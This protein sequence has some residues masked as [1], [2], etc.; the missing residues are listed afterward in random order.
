MTIDKLDMLF[1]IA[2]ENGIMIEYV[3]FP[4]NMEGLYYKDEDIPPVI[5]IDKRITYDKKLFTCVL[6]E[7][8]GHHFTTVGDCTAEY[9]CY[10]DRLI[11]N[12]KETLALKWATEFLMP[13]EEIIDYVKNNYCSFGELADKLQVTE[14]FL[15]KRFE[16]I[17]RHS[18]YIKIDNS[19]CI[20]LT[21]LPNIYFSKLF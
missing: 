11:V 1:E 18:N 5:G 20:M 12:K 15:Y 19:S 10:S 21:S 3:H 13:I 4:D 8:I 14:H 9:Y 2:E 7:E 6:A 16:F 17:S